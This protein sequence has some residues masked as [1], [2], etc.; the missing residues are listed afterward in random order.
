MVGSEQVSY[1]S[2]IY[3]IERT[4]KEYLESADTR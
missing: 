3:D 1:G 4:Y 2:P